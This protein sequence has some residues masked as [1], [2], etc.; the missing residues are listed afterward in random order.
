MEAPPACRVQARP[1]TSLPRRGPG[2]TLA[3][4]RRPISR[5]AR[6]SL[7]H[8]RA[9]AG[10]PV[11]AGSRVVVDARRRVGPH[12]S[13]RRT[14]RTRC[15]L[16]GVFTC[17][18]SRGRA[19]CGRWSRLLPPWEQRARLRGGRWCWGRRRRKTPGGRGGG[20]LVRT[21]LRQELWPALAAGRSRG[22]SLLPLAGARLHD[23]FS[24]RRV[25][26]ADHEPK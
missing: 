9:P 19:W 25:R 26:T 8:I 22:L 15:E 3:V 5:G 1:T 14:S 11:I 2:L 6:V 7:A 23:A 18:R 16:G 4:L 20:A 10:V 17:S 21:A 12:D 24:A 13:V